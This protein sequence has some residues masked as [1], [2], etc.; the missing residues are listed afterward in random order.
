VF[1][2]MIPSFGPAYPAEPFLRRPI[3]GRQ[4]P[5]R[6]HGRRTAGYKSSPMAG[7]TAGRQQETKR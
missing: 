4:A 7:L 6:P 5:Y 3:S 1:H 2:Q